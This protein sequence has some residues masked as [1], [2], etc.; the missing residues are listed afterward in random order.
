MSETRV[1]L[2]EPEN[3]VVRIR[4]ESDS[5]IQ[6]L[7]SAV[8]KELLEHLKTLA[9]GDP[10]RVVVFEAS[11]R[12]FLAGANLHELQEL[13][14]QSAR[15]YSRRGQK[16]FRRIAELPSITVAAIHGACAGGGCELS[17][18]CDFR[19][20]ASSARIGLPEVT[21]GLIPGWGGTARLV[22]QLG[23]AT[24]RR[25]ILSGELIPAP[26]ALR[27]GLAQEVFSDAEFADKVSEKI[28]GFQK[29]APLAVAAAKRL[30][31][32]GHYLDLSDFLEEEARY[33]GRCYGTGE[34]HEGVRAFLEKRVA[35]WPVS[36]DHQA[37]AD[38]KEKT[39]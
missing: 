5:G 36:V 9:S 39:D 15:R 1:V 11:G 18:S 22:R 8:C 33:F 21:L 10:P 3:G 26:E 30:I 13:N 4:F 31:A 20:L 6:I 19:Y 29:C 32:E 7:S 17:L 2:G 37:A 25:L 14:R 16:L 35:R 23:P 12:T 28:A 24:A 38:T 34:P 27:L